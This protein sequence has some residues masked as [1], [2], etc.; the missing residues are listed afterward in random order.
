MKL[1]QV[2]Y[3]SALFVAVVIA[4]LVR[5]LVF[6]FAIYN[7]IPDE[8]GAP[9]S[10]TLV[11]SSVDFG[12]YSQAVETYFGGNTGTIIESLRSFYQDPRKNGTGY[13]APAPLFPLFIL[14]FRY[15]KGNTLPLSICYLILSCVFCWA[16]LKWLD[17]RQVSG[18]WL[19][20]FALVPNPIWYMLV[21]SS[22]LLFA[23]LFCGFYLYYFKVS[24]STRDIL[25]WLFFGA[26]LLLTR[27]N[28]TSIAL[29]VVAD[30]IRRRYRGS[31][32]GLLMI[33]GFI[34]FSAIMVVFFYPYFI[35]FV[36]ASQ[37]LPYFGYAPADYVSGIYESL[38]TWLDRVL[39]G[40]SLVF[41]KILYAVGLRP[42]YGD[43]P[44]HLVV[45]RSALG[46]VLLP[47]LIYIA[48]KGDWAH[49]LLVGLALVPVLVGASQDRY[50]LF[51]QPVIFFFGVRAY[52]A[53]WALLRDRPAFRAVRALAGN[54]DG[55]LGAE[56]AP[57]E[58]HRLNRP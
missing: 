42:S 16:W 10:P 9:V 18:L 11:T 25:L 31:R 37:K 41:A 17:S 34:L 23:A 44:F 38:P 2:P 51:I 14:G 52:G 19:G 27:P 28:A 47:G 55:R 3:R 4:V 57:P 54:R 6:V 5:L 46:I 15:E 58:D 22:D 1:S 53:T 12:F 13:I 35:V 21:V 7:P 29:F 8:K 30:I 43:T 20:L 32:M 50:L 26:A 49:R 45:L 40:L 39:S 56:R 36:N 24:W 48:V 33:G